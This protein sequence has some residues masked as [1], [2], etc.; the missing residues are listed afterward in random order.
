MKR[1]LLLISLIAICDLAMAQI[2]PHIKMISVDSLLNKIEVSDSIAIPGAMP[3]QGMQYV[4]SRGSLGR[5]A[6]FHNGSVVRLDS[7]RLFYWNLSGNSQVTDSIR[8]IAAGYQG[9]SQTGYTIT[10]WPDTSAHKLATKSDLLSISFADSSRASH[11]SDSTKK[12]PSSDSV[13]AAHVADTALHVPTAG[14]ADSAR[15]S[16]ISDTTKKVAVGG[17]VGTLGFADSSRASHVSDTTKA[18]SAT[19]TGTLRVAAGVL[20]ATASDSAGFG[21]ALALKAPLAS[22]VFTTAVTFPTAWTGTIR[23]ASG[24][25]SATAS[26][27]IGYGAA[28]ATKIALADSGSVYTSYYVGTL[29]AP[30]ASPTFTG[31]PIFNLGSDAA[32]DIW[33]RAATTGYMTRLALGT[34]NQYLGVGT[35]APAWKASDTIGVGAAIAAK[36]AASVYDTVKAAIGLYGETA[37]DSC[38]MFIVEEQNLTLLSAYVYR[39]G[40]TT[41]TVNFTRDSTNTRVDLFSSNIPVAAYAGAAMTPTTA[42]IQNVTMRS[43]FI[44][45]GVIRGIT[46]TVTETYLQ[47][48]FIKTR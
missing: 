33:Y 31:T 8:I 43:G 25:L 36:H 38:V 15:A 46:G 28:L 2:P 20:T 11:I 14:T 6:K 37:K 29:K 27:S 39:L 21:A 44:I 34:T 18:V 1:F 19:L 45:R 26:D 12:A 10:L 16:H 3:P 41:D 35:N 17:I 13:R 30:L 32:G 23:A 48:N 40:G 24:V 7:V 42:N 47:L 4:F 22:P 5:F 9:S